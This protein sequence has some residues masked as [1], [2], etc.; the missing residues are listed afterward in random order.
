M[1]RAAG[2]RCSLR[3]RFSFGW[4]IFW[5][6]IKRGRGQAG[7]GLVCC[8]VAYRRPL[9]PSLSVLRPHDEGWAP[10]SRLAPCLGR[11]P[12]SGKMRPRLRAPPLFTLPMRR[13]ARPY[14]CSRLSARA[15]F[16]GSPKNAPACCVARLLRLSR[17]PLAL[18]HPAPAL[19]GCSFPRVSRCEPRSSYPAREKGRKKGR[20]IALPSARSA[21]AHPP[22]QDV[23]CP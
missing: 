22:P 1:P 7:G 9:S 3:S 16:H 14:A 2:D 10:C 21:R 13:P 12:L 20:A 8:M 6:A 18:E 23:L 19:R 15:P 4:R 17:E 5:G 11:D